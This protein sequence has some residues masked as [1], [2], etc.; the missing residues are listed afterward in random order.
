MKFYT[1]IFLLFAAVVAISAEE[2]DNE[3]EPRTSSSLNTVEDRGR[4]ISDLLS[5]YDKRN[6]PSNVTVQFGVSLLKLDVDELASTLETDLWTR[7]LWI[8][9][10]LRWNPEEY[11]NIT[12]LRLPPSEIWRPDITLYNSANPIDNLQCSETNILVYNTGKIIWVPPCHYRSHCNLSLDRAPLDEQTCPLKFGSWTFDGYSLDLQFYDEKEQ[13][14][15][16]DYMGISDW[17][18]TGNT[19]ERLSKTYDCCPEPYVTRKS[20]INLCSYLEIITLSAKAIN[21]LPR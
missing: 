3:I 5:S 14:D 20:G 2:L 7:Q 19:A 10:R 4:L 16:I 9:L 1:K 18:L 11:G 8:D 13:A 15:I 12:V 6:Y 17:E 21:I